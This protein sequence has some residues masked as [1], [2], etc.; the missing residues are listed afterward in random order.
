M[1]ST[2]ELILS[3]VKPLIA[4]PF[5]VLM[6][7]LASTCPLPAIAAMSVMQGTSTIVGQLCVLY[8]VARVM[9]NFI[10]RFLGVT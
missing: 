1:R 5:A 7:D 3:S 8:Y 10:A 2:S 6:R 4:L 9:N